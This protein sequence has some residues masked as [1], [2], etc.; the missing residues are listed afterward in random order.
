MNYGKNTFRTWNAVVWME[1]NDKG[2]GNLI[3]KDS[4]ER[5]QSSLG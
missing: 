2:K 5:S 4:W 1:Y 3:Y